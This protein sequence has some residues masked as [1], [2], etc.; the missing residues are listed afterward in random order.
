MGW[1]LEGIT[2]LY[3]RNPWQHRQD[4][5]SLHGYSKFDGITGLNCTGRSTGETT[6]FPRLKVVPMEWDEV[7]ERQTREINRTRERSADEQ[8]RQNIKAMEWL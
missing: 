1:R 3:S 5:R 2:E 7:R 4:G 6:D 8:T